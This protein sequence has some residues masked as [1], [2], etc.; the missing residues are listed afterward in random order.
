[1]RD[2]DVFAP[3]EKATEKERPMANN[4][5]DNDNRNPTDRR[6]QTNINDPNRQR[7][8]DGQRRQH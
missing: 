4:P 6:E 5:R 3:M 2:G 7:D 8:N 1:M